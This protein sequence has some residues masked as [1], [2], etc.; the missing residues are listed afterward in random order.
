MKTNHADIEFYREMMEHFQAESASKSAQVRAM[1]DEIAALRRE[2]SVA[3]E[4]H[5]EDMELLRQ[6]HREDM[7][8]LRRSHEESIDSLRKS[9]EKTIETMQASFEKR[10]DRMAEANAGLAA[11]LGD[12]LASGK[13]ARARKYAR[14]SEQRNLLNNRKGVN[15]TEEEDDSDGTP[16]SDSGRQGAAD[17]ENTKSRSRVRAKGKPEGKARLKTLA[18]RPLI[19]DFDT[20]VNVLDAEMNSA[21]MRKGV[22]EFCRES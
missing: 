14:S 13:L 21:T 19:Y 4:S 5:R 3:K 1:Q 17:T 7:E 11:Q 10:L 15:R 22:R 16:P 9:Y 2:N 8:A 6:S 12:A 18:L 20:C